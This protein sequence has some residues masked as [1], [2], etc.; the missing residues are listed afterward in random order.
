M[1][2]MKKGVLF[3]LG[4]TGI[5]LVIVVFSIIIYNNSINSKE[6]T[7]HS[8]S[9]ERVSDL[10]SSIKS[11]LKKIFDLK[12]NINLSIINNTAILTEELS[13]T[14]NESFTNSIQTFKAFIEN[15][16]QEN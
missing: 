12:S 14:D 2:N 7:L 5:M 10:E 13:N 9:I 3:T 4:I 11:S 16:S 1:E 8:G 6:T 15:K